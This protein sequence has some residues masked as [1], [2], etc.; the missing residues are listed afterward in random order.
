MIGLLR[1][2]LLKITSTRLGIGL[3]LAAVGYVVIDVAALVFAAGQQGIPALTTATSVRNVYAAA[4]AASPIVLVVGIL[5]MTSEYRYQTVTPTFLVTPRRSRVLTAKLVVNAAFGLV[6]GLA[7]ALVAVVLGSGL[8]SFK[9]HAPIAGG[10]VLQICVSTLLGY[11]L[12]AVVG[13]SVGA[14]VRNQVAAILGALLWALVVEAL[15]VAFAPSVGRWLPGGALSSTLQA[16]SF[17]GGHLLPV[18]AGA[19]VLVAYTVVIAV[20]AARTTLRQDVT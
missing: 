14:L 10:T 18:W 3:V 6:I 1:A 9:T 12:Y 15:V 7:C 17:N 13:V 4:G 11:A 16:T 2:E 5:A 8:L 19:A 20:V